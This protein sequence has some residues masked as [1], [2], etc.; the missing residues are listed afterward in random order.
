M[1][2]KRP[3]PDATVGANNGL[4]KKKSKSQDNET[5]AAGAPNEEYTWISCDNGKDDLKRLEIKE[6]ARREAE[7]HAAKIEKILLPMLTS[8]VPDTDEQNLD[9]A[10]T[11]ELNDW[12][13]QLGMC[14]TV[15]MEIPTYVL[16]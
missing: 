15:L 16:L 13:I 9:N 5:E 6:Q 3:A 10:G 14:S 2:P 4:P 1:P 8:R 7:L 12:V 11:E